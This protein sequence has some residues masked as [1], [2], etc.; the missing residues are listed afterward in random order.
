LFDNIE[1]GPPFMDGDHLITASQKFKVLDLL[2]PKLIKQDFKVLIFSQ[3]T[4]LLNI[5]DDFLRY[6]GYKY[7]RIDGQ[8]S[9]DDRE[10]R[11]DD[12]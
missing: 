3:M 12:F 11:I 10:T 5:L 9:A 1:P 6:R 4:R 2:L 7:C 8:T